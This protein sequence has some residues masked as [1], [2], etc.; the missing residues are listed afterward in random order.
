MG[1]P[2]F[3]DE[4]LQLAQQT[5]IENQESVQAARGC[6]RR[7]TKVLRLPKVSEVEALYIANGQL[8]GREERDGKP[9]NLQQEE[10]SLVVHLEP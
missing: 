2:G 4:P 1:G 6:R 8:L 9:A 5:V 3:L 10:E 7:E